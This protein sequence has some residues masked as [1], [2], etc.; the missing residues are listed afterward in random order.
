MWWKLL[1]GAGS[2]ALAVFLVLT[3]GN[4]REAQGRL[5]E[6]VAAA[7]R[8]ALA[9]RQAGDAALAAERRV[10]AAWATMPPAP[11]RCALSSPPTPKRS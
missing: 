5:T 6:Q 1:A 9:D 7:K 10:T 3:Y 4:A 11:R 8:Q 2:L